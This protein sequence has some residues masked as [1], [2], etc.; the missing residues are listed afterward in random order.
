MFLVIKFDL[1]MIQKGEPQQYFLKKKNRK[2]KNLEFKQEQQKKPYFYGATLEYVGWKTNK[3]SI[4]KQQNKKH[5]GKI[6]CTKKA[7]V[8]SKSLQKT[9]LLFLLLKETLLK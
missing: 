8:I 4:S 2:S 9:F 5:F 3:H 1:N 7:V 6:V